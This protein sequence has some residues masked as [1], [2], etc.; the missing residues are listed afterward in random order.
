MVGKKPIVFTL[1]YKSRFQFRKRL[2]LLNQSILMFRNRNEF[3]ITETELKLIA[4]AAIMGDNN[5]PNIGNK[6][7]AAI[8]TPN[9][10]Y[11][12]EK[13]RFCLMFFIT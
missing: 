8:G 6:T 7:P 9:T 1:K 10:L 3:V 11:T 2:F 4:K 12:N 5:N 13:N